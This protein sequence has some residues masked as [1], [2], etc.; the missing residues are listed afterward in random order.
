MLLLTISEA[1]EN[2]LQISRTSIWNC[3]GKLK[4]SQ[5]LCPMGA[6]NLIAQH[7]TMTLAIMFLQSHHND[8]DQFMDRFVT[9]EET[10]I[11]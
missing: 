3:N 7:K 9:G 8:G 5:T 6:K 2:F 1:S 11:R 4:F 10:W